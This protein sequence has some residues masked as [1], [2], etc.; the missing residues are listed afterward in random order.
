MWVVG[1][2]M[3]FGYEI[4][5]DDAYEAE[6]IGLWPERPDEITGRGADPERGPHR[7]EPDVPDRPSLGPSSGQLGDA[8]GAGA[9]IGVAAEEHRGSEGLRA[10]LG[11]ATQRSDRENTRQAVSRISTS[12]RLPQK[13]SD[14]ATPRRSDESVGATVNRQSESRR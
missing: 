8:S 9:V 3:R 11:G 7:G 14:T 1:V 10:G 13:L 4:V 5:T 6:R 12:S 2:E